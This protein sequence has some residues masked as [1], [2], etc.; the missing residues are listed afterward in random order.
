[1]SNGDER[2]VG[3]RNSLA[4]MEEYF[5]RVWR[6]GPGSVQAPIRSRGPISDAV[7]MGSKLRTEDRLV[8]GAASGPVGVIARLKVY[9][10]V[11]WRAFWR[12]FR[13]Q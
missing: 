6:S 2:L 7:G 5:V 8:Q 13:G 11:V 4:T 1:M 3:L 9:V 12:V 10:S